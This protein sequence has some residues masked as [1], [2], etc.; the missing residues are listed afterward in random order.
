MVSD[1]CIWLKR[2]VIGK[3][4]D[5]AK[6]NETGLKQQRTNENWSSNKIWVSVETNVEY[7]VVS[8]ERVLKQKD[9]EIFSF[10]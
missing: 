5:D 1:L 3:P 9:G 2:F 10:R 4:P 6:N 8:L 7:N